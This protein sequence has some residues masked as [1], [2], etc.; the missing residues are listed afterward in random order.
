MTQETLGL[1]APEMIARE[2]SN[3]RKVFIKTYGCQ[4]NVYDSVRMSDALAKDG[5]VQTEDMGEADLVLLN[6]CHIREKAAEKVYS[7]LGRLRDM[8]KSREEQGREFVIGVAG[9]VAQAEGEEIL[10]RAPAVDVVIGPQ[11]YHR[12]PDALKRVRGGERVIETEY[13]VEDKFEHLPVAEK[14]T[15]RTRG[16]TAF[17]TVQEGCDKF[18]TFCV[19]PYTR[20]SEVSR[21]VRQIVDEAMKLVDAGVREITLLGQNVNAWQGEGSK[22]EKW[23]LAEL[24]YRLAEIPGLARLRYTT[25]HPRDMD[26]RLIGAHRDLRILM[27]YL[28]LPVQSGSDRILKAMNRRHTGEE[29]IQ[30]IEK[31]RAARPDIAMSGD[32]I[33]GFPGETDRDFEDT[34]AIIEQVKYA[35]AFSFKYSTRPGTPGADLTDQVAEEVK[36]ERLERLQALLLRQQKEFAESLVG[37]T[38]DVLLEKPGRMPEQLIGRSPWLQSVNLDAKTLKI[39]DIVNVRITATGPNSLFAEVA[40][41]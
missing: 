9:C 27:P 17:L 34:M 36:A 4:M 24:L 40:E 28:H 3:S 22:G 12:L 6:T 1:D 8:K 16:V 15:L 32:F 10:R 31:I 19:V 13:A 38:M 25:S 35:Q 41:S 37:K 29:Y 14:A 11:T 5:Y 30:L 23:G 33:V 26:D 39:G 18:C 7:A 2:G 20:G 21:P